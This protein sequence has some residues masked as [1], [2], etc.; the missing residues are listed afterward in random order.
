[1]RKFISKF[2]FAGIMAGLLYLMVNPTALQEP[3]YAQNPSGDTQLNRIR[4][5][6]W[7]DA[8]RDVTSGQVWWV[9][10]SSA[11]DAN[12]AAHGQ[13]PMQPFTTIAYAI[14]RVNTA[15]GD[16]IYVMPGHTETL[17]SA[18]EISITR[19]SPTSAVGVKVVGL[20]YGNSRPIISYATATTASLRVTGA[21]ATLENLIFDLTGIDA[22]VSPIEIRAA[23]FTMRNCHIITATAGGQATRA[24][25]TTNAATAMTLE[26][27]TFLGTINAGTTSVLQIVGGHS[28]VIRRN[29]FMGAYTTT[30]GA[31]EGGTP[32]TENIIIHGNWIFNRTASSS[33][34]ITLFGSSTG[35]I[36]DNRMQV[37]TGSDPADCTGCAPPG[38]YHPPT[39]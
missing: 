36:S 2:A 5:I 30:V 21:N 14:T 20:G 6:P 25:V 13:D 17:D 39:H 12:D 19:A 38:N 35:I 27:N 8:S 4:G 23:G 28:H 22:L 3:T 29:V 18:A 37:L 1:M 31:I 15:N 32:L 10:A 34:A 11:N 33:K 26:D 9:G 16:V 24:I 7:M